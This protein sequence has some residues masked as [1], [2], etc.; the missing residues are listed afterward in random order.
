MKLKVGIAGV[1]IFGSFFVPLFQKHPDV[2]EVYLADINRDRL[3]EKA[4]EFGIKKTFNSCQELCNSDCDC[5]AIFTQRWSHAPLAIQALKAGKH[6]YSAVPAAMSLEE[7]EELV[8]TVRQTGMIY[9]MG[10][11]SYYRPQSMFCRQKFR[12]GAF[13]QFVY[14]EGHYY[15]DMSHFYKSFMRSNGQDW[16]TF[17]SIP[18]MYYPTHSTAFILGVTF[19]R[20]TEVSCMG[21]VD[22]HEDGI[23]NS[24][25]S[26]WGNVFSNQSALFRT[27]DGGMARVN[28]FRRVGEGLDSRIFKNPYSGA[29]I[30]GD[31]RMAFVGSQGS[32][33][34]QVGS[35]IF[36]HHS[37][38]DGYRKNGE[39][40]FEQA[41]E[42][43][44]IQ[45]KDVSDIRNFDGI[46]LTEENLGDFPR[47]YL[48]K[49]I[50]GISKIQPYH[51]LPVEFLDIKNGHAGTHVFMVNDFVRSVV[52]NKL[53]QNNVWQAARYMAPGIVAHESC[54]RDGEL[55]KIPDFGLPD[56]T[57]LPLDPECVLKS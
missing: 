3:N 9:M 4:A 49:K 21:Y 30:T 7:L 2:S 55:L 19:Q 43:V 14:G 51:Q 13:G 16:K 37:I 8:A 17:A 46:E 52:N 22:S 29:N 1:S 32:Y 18:P 57:R 47:S 25:L 54:K 38:S 31:G 42:L 50:V 23:F 12:E 10:E 11:T 44:D 45:A 26:K 39:I 36:T 24:E 53:P 40:N 5:I 35:S 34:E 56:D 20:M 27:S 28:E 48:G 41:K 33:Q 6:V 15:H